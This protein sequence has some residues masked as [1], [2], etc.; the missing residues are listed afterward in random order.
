MSEKVKLPRV[1]DSEIN[2]ALKDIENS[3]NVIFTILDK[4]KSS[5]SSGQY[6]ETVYMDFELLNQRQKKQYIAFE[7]E[8]LNHNIK[9]EI[10]N[11]GDIRFFCMDCHYREDVV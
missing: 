3:L 11:N 1:D 2:E 8:H 6:Q 7:R 4:Y 10:N 9:I 5:D